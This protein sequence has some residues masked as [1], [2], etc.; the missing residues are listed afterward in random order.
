VNCPRC[1]VEL[2][3]EQYK[4]IEVDK[5]PN[6]QGMWLDYHEL[7]QLEDIAFD[8]DELKGTMVYSPRTSKL[9][10]PRCKQP[11]KAF[12][13]RAYYDLELDFCPDEHGFWL[14]AGEEKRVLE[15][16]RQAEKNLKRKAAT[17]AEWANFLRKAGSKSFFDR[18]KGLFRGY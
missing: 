4:G 15:L 17:E 8:S 7:D 1:N 13:Y 2:E 12:E 9:L 10:C 14:D 3:L 5:C 6:C 11:M 18:I 16:M